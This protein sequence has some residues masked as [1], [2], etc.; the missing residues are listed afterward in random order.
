MLELIKIAQNDTVKVTILSHYNTNA[1][2]NFKQKRFT[3]SE[4]LNNKTHNK[5][6]YQ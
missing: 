5:L 2:A 1:G 4:P 3:M 6:A